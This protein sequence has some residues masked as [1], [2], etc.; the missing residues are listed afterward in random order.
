MES[1]GGDGDGD[2][3]GDGGGGVLT[4]GAGFRSSYWRRRRLRAVRRVES[5]FASTVSCA[6]WT[7]L[8]DDATERCPE[9][10]SQS[11]VGFVWARRN[12]S[13]PEHR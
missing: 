8:T 10:P 7:C 12:S 11:C 5:A 2:G 13:S 3:D 4:A 6:A 9:P 1:V